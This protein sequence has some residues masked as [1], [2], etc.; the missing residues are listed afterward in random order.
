MDGAVWARAR[1]RAFG[2][3][4][5]SVGHN[6]R[7]SQ[8]GRTSGEDLGW[9]RLPDTRGAERRAS[10]GPSPLRYCADMAI[11]DP[12][13][14]PAPSAQDAGHRA[15]VGRPADTWRY[16]LDLIRAIA[17]V[18]VVTI[19]ATDA[20]IVLGE[21]LATGRAYWLALGLNA[22][23]L[24]AVRS[25]SP[26]QAG[27]C[28]VGRSRTA[29]RGCGTGSCASAS[30]SSSGRSIPVI[31]ATIGVGWLVAG[32]SV[33]VRHRLTGVRDLPRPPARP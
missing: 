26:C 29:R 4:V 19:H 12:L 3:A 24:C 14:S 2:P 28:C 30:P 22:T 5:Q 1:E 23:S 10:P 33:P 7:W 27:A 18:M 21:K 32:R 15:D 25:S 16:D 9:R 31:A 17:A 13:A 8:Q 6:S 11:D 20:D